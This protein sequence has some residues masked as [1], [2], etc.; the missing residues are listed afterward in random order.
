[1][2]AIRVGDRVLYEGKRWRV[3][4]LGQHAYQRE[5]TQTIINGEPYATLLL[6]ADSPRRLEA[7]LRAREEAFDGALREDRSAGGAA[8]D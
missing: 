2:A 3:D 5:G 1:M 4:S 7:S 8:E 6:Q